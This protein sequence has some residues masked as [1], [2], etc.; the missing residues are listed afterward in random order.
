MTGVID[1]PT[2]HLDH[3]GDSLEC[4]H[5]GG[6]AVGERALFELALDAS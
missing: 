6:I 4:P 1:H 3:L 2:F 5:V